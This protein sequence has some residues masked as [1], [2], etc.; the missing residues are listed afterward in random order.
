MGVIRFLIYPAH[1]LDHWPEAQRA[2]VRGFDGHVDATRIEI[3][4]NVLSCTRANSESGKF[5]IA[6]PVPG[7]GRPFISTSTLREREEAYLLPVELAR[8]KICQ[9]RNQFAL[10]ER[11]GMSIP[12]EFEL[13][14]R[15]AH[16]KFAKSVAIQ[17]RPEESCEL[18][19]EAI[20]K[21]C[22]A[23]EIL[24][25]AYA[26]QRLTVRRRRSANL[27][28]ALGC[29][30]GLAPPAAESENQLRE[31]FNTAAIPIEWRQIEPT[32]GD[33]A[34]EPNDAQVEWC[35]QNHLLIRGGPLLD[36]SPN[37]LPAWLKQWEHDFLNLQSFL[38]DFVE[39]AITRYAGKIRIWEVSARVNT[40]GA[41][42]ISEENRLT[43]VAR[44]LEVARQVDEEAQ[45]LIRVD[46][47]WGDYQSQ[48]K[49]R[50]SPM[51]FVDALA[52]CGVGLSGVNLEVG[53]GY[54]PSGSAMRDLL[55]FSRLI[56]QW[57]TL[58]IPLHVTLAFPSSGEPDANANGA[59]RKVDS[60]SWRTGW[61]DEAQT[62]WIS[63]YLP[64]LMAKESVNGVFWSHFS[65]AASHEYPHAGLLRA[66]G[67]PKPALHKI[68]EQRQSNWK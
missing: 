67:S 53:V 35:L 38:C 64:L 43:L 52:R 63:L 31:A 49:H 60:G 33:Y 27:P 9:V 16:T 10:W 55:D 12:D 39:T 24:T 45:L 17:D 4:G 22:A 61:T 20:A 13:R 40:G 21:A 5:S 2:H 54:H 42:N 66:D 57:S 28:T 48:G 23:A 62:E 6:F 50:L 37:G 44:T 15:E 59:D 11:A 26:A 32:E 47:P 29:N 41:M 34:W 14:H 51:Q 58:E 36:L 25:Q 19:I 56:D 7:F 46:Q 3:D 65:D 18:A 30:L 8:G 68:I 1:L